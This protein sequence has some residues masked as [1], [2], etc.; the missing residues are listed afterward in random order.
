MYVCMFACMYLYMY[1]CVIESPRRAT[2]R[3]SIDERS[4]NTPSDKDATP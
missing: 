3:V 1:L 2:H 4:W